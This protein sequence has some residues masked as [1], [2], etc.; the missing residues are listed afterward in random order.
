MKTEYN[1]PIKSRDT[2]D[3]LA[4]VENADNWKQDALTQA[5]AELVERGYSIQKQKNRAKSKKRY[6]KKVASIK[7]D[8][9]YKRWEL[10]V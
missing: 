5:R 9:T 1:P 4:I 8:K 3:L 7:A 2:K 6:T 10:I